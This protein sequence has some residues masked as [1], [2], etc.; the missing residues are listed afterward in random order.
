MAGTLQ[1]LHVH[2]LFESSQKLCAVE[3]VSVPILQVRKLRP[4][5]RHETMCSGTTQQ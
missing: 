2:S 4:K 1:G 3:V 5:G